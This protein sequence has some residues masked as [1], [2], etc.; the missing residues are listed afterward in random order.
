MALPEQKFERVDNFSRSGLQP[1]CRHLGSVP[2][3]GALQFVMSPDRVA[4]A[5]R[6]RYLPDFEHGVQHALTCS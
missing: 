6:G 5:G 1:H 4:L 2:A 3:Q